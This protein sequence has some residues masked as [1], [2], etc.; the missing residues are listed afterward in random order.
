MTRVG[1]TGHQELPPDA[2]PYLVESVRRIL[3][4][5]APPL[6][7]ITALAAGADQLVAREVLRDGGSLHA[8]VP[9]VGYETT[10]SRA[11][12][13]EYEHLLAQADE[14][15]RLD[16]PEPSEEAYWAAGKRVVDEC[17]VLVAIWDGDPA[18]GLGGTA[19]VVAYA[20]SRGKDIRVVW[21]TGLIRA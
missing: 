8:I 19:D 3:E 5:C 17:E 16:F 6:R 21:P 1:A 7:A 9:A 2:S 15:T 12:L 18:R 11:D 10:F 14:V 4:Q 20:Q 13:R